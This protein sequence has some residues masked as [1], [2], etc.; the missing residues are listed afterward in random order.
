MENQEQKNNGMELTTH[1][2]FNMLDPQ[3]FDTMQRLCKLYAKSEI[4]PDMYRES[5]KN[6]LDKAMANS[7]I[8]LEMAFRI[9]A[10]PLMVM[11]NMFIVYG[12]PAWSSTFLIATVNGC[13]RF[14]SL[15]FSNIEADGEIEIQGSKKIPNL[16]CYAWTTEKGSKDILKGSVISISMAVKE[17]WYLK[18][19]SKWQTMPEQML[20]YRAAAFWCRTYAPELSM[21]IKTTDEVEDIQ[22]IEEATYEEIKNAP[23]KQEKKEEQMQQNK[24]F[25]ESGQKEQVKEE[26]QQP[27]NRPF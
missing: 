1:K 6:P 3:Q 21:G 24:S 9:G 11:Q 27:I 2:N 4:V 22:D 16:T 20:R 25:D 18:G 8:A 19:G 14:N 17:G 15:K 5:N 10:S 7:L 12:I 26:Q 13:G 23:I